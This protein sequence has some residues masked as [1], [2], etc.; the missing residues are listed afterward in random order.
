MAE[1]LLQAGLR[2]LPAK[3]AAA[4]SIFVVPR[5]VSSH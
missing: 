2:P 3:L 1:A 5:R 4:M